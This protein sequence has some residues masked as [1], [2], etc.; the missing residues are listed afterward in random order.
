M[1]VDDREITRKHVNFMS[2]FAISGGLPAT[3]G[4]GHQSHRWGFGARL[5][6]R[7]Q[8]PAGTEKAGAP[9]PAPT[10]A[11][12]T[13]PALVTPDAKLSHRQDDTR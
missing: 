4:V 9:A 12:V 11:L 7:T 1:V 5:R 13:P 6:E 8:V 10:T 3:A 2:R